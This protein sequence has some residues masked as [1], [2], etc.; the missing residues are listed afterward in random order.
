MASSPGATSRRPAQSPRALS[1]AELDTILDAAATDLRSAHAEA[2]RERLLVLDP[3]F[4]SSPERCQLAGLILIGA[5]DP[6]EALGWFARARTL[7]PGYAEAA[8]QMG[9]VFQQLGRCQEA[10]KAYDEALGLGLHDAVAFYNRGIVLRVLGRNDEAI[11]S[12]DQALRLKP[13]YPDALRAGAVLLGEAGQ[14]ENALE[15]IEEALRIKPDFYE[16]HLDRANLLHRLGS[17]EAALSACSEALEVFPGHP[18]LINNRAVIFQELG[19]L[20][21]ALA[22]LDVALAAK[23]N[24]PEALFNRGV[25]L[26]KLASP[27]E[28]LASFDRALSLAPSYSA[29]LVGRGVALKEQGC[30][31]EADAAFD[32]ALRYEPES[33]HAKNNK[34]ALHLLRGDFEQ[35]WEGYESRWISGLTSKA[36][37]QF[38]IPEWTGKYRAGQKLIVF[39]E[40][41]FGDTFQFSRFLPLIARTGTDVT[42]FCRS[43]LL[44][45]MRGLG[46]KVHCLDDFGPDETFDS[47]IALLSLPRAL[48]TRLDSI[49]ANVPYLSPEPELVAKWAERLSSAE[50]FKIG[51]CWHG[52]PN[53]RADP[54]RSMPLAGFSRLARAGV[55]LVSLQQRDGLSELASAP[56]EIESLGDDFDAGPDAFIDTAA[57]MQSLDLIVTC[58]TSVAHLAGALGRPVFVMLKKIPDWR[59]L[60]DRDD[61][62]WYPTM[63]LFRQKERG[64]WSDVMDRVGAAIDAMRR[65]I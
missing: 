6:A 12:F 49:P 20:E 52:S 60:L 19:E 4:V 33:A 35:G 63:R 56:F 51:L 22:S 41:G 7:R 48:A 9:A 24:F 27:E 43:S 25:L 3:A 8:S 38:P 54:A 21:A 53:A 18:D 39:D 61:S 5:K 26:L 55:H 45:L 57:V 47:Q 1:E 36:K 28:A 10:L 58:D 37:L 40:Q 46:S 44:R 2:A 30:F 59:W 65:G 11:A 62:P 42:F 13:A 34:G 23:P 31:V 50:Q 14:L 29:A 17:L 16:A 64:D 32:L 15:F